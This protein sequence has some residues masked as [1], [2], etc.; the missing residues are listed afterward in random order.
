MPP[1]GLEQHGGARDID[2]GIDGQ[3]GQVHA[4][5]DHG[6]LVTNRV[7]P[8]QGPVDRRGVTNVADYQFAGDMTGPAVVHGGG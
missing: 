8:G 3:V 2:V 7:D 5:P 6:R 4:E 1:H